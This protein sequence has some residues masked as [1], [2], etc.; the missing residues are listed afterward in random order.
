MTQEND[1]RWSKQLDNNF[2]YYQLKYR[3]SDDGNENASAF[4]SYKD[5]LIIYQ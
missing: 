2:T 5:K 1:H 4:V 3:P